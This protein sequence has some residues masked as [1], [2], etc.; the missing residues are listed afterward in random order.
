MARSRVACHVSH[1]HH[2]PVGNAGVGHQP[3]HRPVEAEVGGRHGRGRHRV[4]VVGRQRTEASHR[5]V[6]QLHG[7][8]AHARVEV[9]EAALQLEA[10]RVFAHGDGERGEAAALRHLPD[11]LRAPERAAGHVEAVLGGGGLEAGLQL[12]VRQRGGRADHVVSHRQKLGP[13]LPEEKTQCN[14]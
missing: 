14:V 11:V 9:A 5:P 10:V 3:P 13:E 1:L 4:D 6:V 7:L 8:R 2:V 12:P